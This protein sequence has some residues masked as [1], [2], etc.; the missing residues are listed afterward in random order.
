MWGPVLVMAL[1]VALDPVRLGILL[2][3]ISRPRPVQNLLA[4]WV[5]SLIASF[6]AALVPLMVVHG[7]PML[8]SFAQDLT[9]PDKVGN[10]TVRHIQIGMGVLMLSITTQMVVCSVLRRR[11]RAQLPAPAG[12]TSALASDSNT[13]T[14]VLWLLSR[15]Q[16]AAAE[17]G[18]AIRRLL[19]RAYNAWEN[20]SLWV[21]WVIGF[22]LGGPGAPELF[23]VLVVIVASGAAIG[24]QVSAVIAFIIGM[25]AVVEIVLV[26]HLT[27]PTK[28]QPL[29]Q[30]L[31]TWVLAHRREIM[32]AMCAVGGAWLLAGGMGTS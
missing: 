11:R 26:S 17:G 18:S 12:N 32:A 20:G 3:V 6:P 7:T 28:T 21:A 10:S 19:G 29:L 8:R 13:P 14:V 9:D 23:V 5:A 30:L 4:Y 22:V 25:L 24:T 2:L 1:L 31:H 16:D 15:A 27:T